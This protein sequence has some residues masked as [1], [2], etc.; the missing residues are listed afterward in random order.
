MPRTGN[1]TAKNSNVRNVMEFHDPQSVVEKFFSACSNFDFDRAMTFI[2]DD[3][4]Y[5]NVPFHTARGKERIRRDLGS[6]EKAMNVF[7]V[8]MVN[9]AVNGNVVL[10]ERVDTL[11]GRFFNVAI[12]LMGTLVVENGKITEWRDFFDWSFAMGKVGKSILT[13]PFKSLR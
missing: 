12:P 8:E 2:D 5:Q 9:I 10:T 7:E 11:G 13:N 6:M 3:C 4:V 1:N